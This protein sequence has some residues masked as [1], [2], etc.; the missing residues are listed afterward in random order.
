MRGRSSRPTSASRNGPPTARAAK[1]DDA[2]AEF[3]RICWSRDR[4]SPPGTRFERGSDHRAGARHAAA[5]SIPPRASS[6]LPIGAPIFSA[7]CNRRARI[8]RR[9]EDMRHVRIRVIDDRIHE[10]PILRIIEL[11]ARPRRRRSVAFEHHEVIGVDR[12]ALLITDEESDIRI[13]PRFV[14]RM[15]VDLSPALPRQMADRQLGL[16]ILLPNRLRGMP[17]S[18]PRRA[19]RA[20]SANPRADTPAPPAPRRTRRGARRR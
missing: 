20:P 10:R 12:L 1:S 2:E 5:P 14:R 6:L 13:T 3:Q 17:R 15:A 11:R 16:R 18:I 4:S 8:G 19:P 7:Y 9:D